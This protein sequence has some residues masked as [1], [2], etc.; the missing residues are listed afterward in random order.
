VIRGKI[1]HANEFETIEQFFVSVFDKLS[2]TVGGLIEESTIKDRG[3]RIKVDCQWINLGFEQILEEMGS[4]GRFRF[5][6]NAL[7]G[8]FDQR[9]GIVD[10]A[11]IDGN[12]QVGI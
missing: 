11:V 4:Q 6:S 7:P 8:Q 10:I 1:G 2:D 9:L 5:G 12:T 3:F